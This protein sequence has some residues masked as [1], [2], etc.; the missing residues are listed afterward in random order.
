MPEPVTVSAGVQDFIARIRM[1][2]ALAGRAEAER[3]VAEASAQAEALLA[4][5]RCEAEELRARADQEAQRLREAGEAAV[6]L[7]F[8]DAV[9]RLKEELGQAFATRLR[10]LVAQELEGPELLRGLVLAVAGRVG[11]ELAPGELE[12]VLVTPA[13]AARDDAGGEQLE[14]LVRGIAAGMLREGVTL[15]RGAPGQG[16][17]LR[18]RLAGEDAE[19]DLTDEAVA[20][21]L[22]ARLLPRFQALLEGFVT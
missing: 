14:G 1:E 20:R 6:R 15:A 12:Q 21:L 16:P 18:L 8:R 7:A 11:G 9:L 19:V 17:G 2:G 5:A 22:E 4:Q 3:V 10:R 13:P